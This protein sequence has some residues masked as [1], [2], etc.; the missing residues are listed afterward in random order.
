[1][2]ELKFALFIVTG[3][4]FTPVAKT[5]YFGLLMFKAPIPAIASAEQ[6]VVQHKSDFIVFFLVFIVTS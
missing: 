1:V 6:A 5:S 4:L 3:M 2:L